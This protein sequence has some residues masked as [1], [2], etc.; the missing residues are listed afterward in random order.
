MQFW[1]HSALARGSFPAFSSWKERQGLCSTHLG[2][3]GRKPSW[4]RAPVLSW[5]GGKLVKVGATTALR[6]MVFPFRIGRNHCGQ[7]LPSWVS[8]CKKFGAGR[9]TR[10]RALSKWLG[11]HVLWVSPHCIY[12]VPLVVGGG[13]TKL[14]KSFSKV[15]L[16]L[17]EGSGL[18][19][20]YEACGS[21][22]T[23]SLFAMNFK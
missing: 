9:Q 1:N 7:A 22:A 23:L 8:H 19:V 3:Q 15:R 5:R 12:C 11:P 16:H 13:G 20:I 17:P 21:P 4:G 6:H 14:W 10:A 2:Q 18:H